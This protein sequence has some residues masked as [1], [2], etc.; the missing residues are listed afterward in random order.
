M[1]YSDY[2]GVPAL[3]F[4][5]KGVFNGKIR[6]DSRLHIDPMLLRNSSIPE[7]QTAYEDL[8]N[9]F[10]KF[11]PL[12]RIYNISSGNRKENIFKGIVKHCM[13]KEL[14]NT[15]L[16][17]STGFGRGNGIS[18]K[19]SRQLADTAIQIIT[20]GFQ[21]PAIFGLL[22]LFEENIGADR[23]SDMT[24][25]IL[26]RHF[27]SYTQRIS[28]ELGLEVRNYRLNYDNC[29][30]VPFIHG[31]PIIFIPESFLA[32]LPLALDFDDIDRVSN[33]NY[34][35]KR[36]L[37]SLIGEEWEKC[38]EFK[39]SDWK[40]FIFDHPE[41]IGYLS[42]QVPKIQPVPYDFDIDDEDVYLGLRVA[43]LAEKE[44]LKVPPTNH[45]DKVYTVTLAICNKF[46]KLVENNQIS[47]LLYRLNRNHDEK[48]W[49]I[50]LY[51]IAESYL[52]GGHYD[53][54][55]S[56]EENPGVGQL[57]F[58]FSYGA[59][60]K[61]VVEIKRSG[62]QNLLHGYRTQLEAYK[63]AVGTTRG[64]FMIIIEEDDALP[65]IHSELEAVIADMKEKGEPLSHVIMIDGRSKP[66][67][68]NPKFKI[69]PIGD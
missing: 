39:K 60:Q 36:K 17:Y 12:T 29:Y 63:N 40:K 62:N 43:Y 46:K 31:N 57:D 52:E 41:C 22:Q 58:L 54:H 11:V 61:V 65:R 55:V 38:R 45:S 9:Y 69:T 35:I 1:Y 47:Q 48:D 49:Q 19:L 50:L 51:A 33:Y 42:A 14:P 5:E 67:A 64:I 27:L 32:T 30:N 24:I 4:K 2:F 23:I 53:V 34:M 6:E 16:G 44:P 7:F 37:A 68:S 18:G 66:S 21:E 56:R 28:S 13:F 8:M 3:S 59:R 15:G 20:A 26:K 10:R 25:A